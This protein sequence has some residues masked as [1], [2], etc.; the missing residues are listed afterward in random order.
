MVDIGGGRRMHIICEG[1]RGAGP[2]VLLEA[3]AFGF[4]ADW[5]AVQDKVVAKG[6]RA[7]SYDRAG[8]GL[9]DPSPDPRDGLA[10]A[11]DLEKL[12][13]AA[14]EP[15]PFILVGHSMAGLRIQLFAGLN[16]GKVAGLVYVDATTP[17]MTDTPSGQTFVKQF[18][19][20][21]RLA[22][23]GASLGLFKPLA[24]TWLGDKYG[25]P[26]AASAEKR[27]AFADPRH[28]RTASAEVDEWQ[29]ASDQ[30]RAVGPL[31][32][33][34]PVAVITASRRGAARQSLQAAP[35]RLSRA[36]YVEN[37]PAASHTSLVGL[38][39]SDAVV[40]GIEHVRHATGRA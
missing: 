21:A 28:N 23:F 6:M 13:A 37:V 36:G 33:A 11:T 5:G 32:P 40:R 12:L 34:W 14:D 24:G 18:A 35:A 22:S 26:P 20:A 17:E 25:L 10:V 15:G 38:A 39:Y 19:R 4:S 9:S 1:P 7:C 30:A 29:V 8:M 3:G 31:D 16:P 2:T 27:R